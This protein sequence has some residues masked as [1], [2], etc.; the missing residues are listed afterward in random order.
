M[1]KWVTIICI[2]LF[3]SFFIPVV[4]AYE[5]HIEGRSAVWIFQ[6]A[7]NEYSK[8]HPDITFKITDASSSTA[9]DNVYRGTIDIASIQYNTTKNGV[10]FSQLNKTVIFKDATIVIVN[11][12]NPINS[13]DIENVR[14]IFREKIDNWGMVGGPFVPIITVGN[15]LTDPKTGKQSGYRRQFYSQILNEEIS[16]SDTNIQVVKNEDVIIRVA[17]IPYAMGYSNFYYGDPRNLDSNLIGFKSVAIK[18]GDQEFHP[19]FENIVDGSYPFQECST[20]CTRTEATLETKEFVDFLLSPRGQIILT[21]NGHVPVRSIAYG[22]NVDV[23]NPINIVYPGQYFLTRDLSSAD[24]IN[25]TNYQ[26]PRWETFFITIKANNVFLDGMGHTIS[27]DTPSGMATGIICTGLYA[28]GTSFGPSSNITIK[29]LTISGGDKGI[30][31]SEVTRV[32]L[33]DIT[34]KNN[35]WALYLNYIDNISINNIKSSSF[36][37]SQIKTIENVN[38]NNIVMYGCGCTNVFLN[39]KKVNSVP[40]DKDSCENYY[41]PREVFLSPLAVFGILIPKL[42]LKFSDIFDSLWEKTSSLT[43][44]AAVI[45]ARIKRKKREIA[46]NHKT[47][48]SLLNHIFFISFIGAIIFGTAFYYKFWYLDFNASILITFIAI[49]SVIIIFH[50]F[51]RYLI[52]KRLKINATYRFWG[53]GIVWMIITT[54]FLPVVVGK[55]THTEIETEN[56]DKKA[57]AL[58]MMSSPLAGL[59]LSIG[60]L[61]LWMQGGWNYYIGFIGIEMSI[62]T[63]FISFFP[64]SPMDGEKVWNWNKALWALIFFPIAIIYFIFFIYPI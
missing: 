35:G 52:A 38:E 62:M 30:R 27:C 6:D 64:V 14:G 29:N 4:Y 41:V 40:G 26:N 60:F 13:L 54:L 31:L 12:G 17:A 51:V 56:S 7:A 45:N 61:F 28:Q 11:S 44:R 5:I 19:T 59:I 10:D 9:L 20:I 1:K 34:F 36:L 47:S 55:P 48:V 37:N 39:N 57:L 63:A 18:V 43:S 23:S 15:N 58:I 32:G 3:L 8:I 42:V 53:W 49:G 24:L 46:K 50:D 25:S 33:D 16:S 22:E 21:K 2:I